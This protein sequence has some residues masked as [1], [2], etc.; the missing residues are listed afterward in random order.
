MTMKQYMN[1]Y[2]QPLNEE[3]I[4]AIEKLTEVAIDKKSKKVK[5]RKGKK[6]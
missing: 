2:K 1:M 3:S 5:K 6:A 4:E